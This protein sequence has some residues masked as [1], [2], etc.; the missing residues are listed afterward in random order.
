MLRALER[1]GVSRQH[2]GYLVEG[3]IEASLRGTDTHGARLFA[4]YLAELDGGRCRARPELRWS[5][6][7]PAVRVLD[8]GHALGPVAG[9]IA[10]REAVHLAEQHG[11]GAVTVRNSNYFGCCAQYTL[12]MARHDV[13]GISS[14]NS[15]ALV[16]PVG[17]G[18]PLFGT[19]PLSFAVR[20]A[21]G[22][23]FCVDMA[24]SQVSFTKIKEHREQGIPLEPGWAV[25][26]DGRDASCGEVTEVAALLP[27]GG[28]KGQCLVMMIEI[29][30][31]LLAG[32]PFDHQLSHL[33]DQPF[34][35]PRQTSH[36]FLALEI[37]AFQPLRSFRA[38]LSELMELVRAQRGAGGARGVAP[39]DLERGTF[40]QRQ[41]Q[42]IPLTEQDLTRFR[43]IDQEDEPGGT[44][45]GSAPYL[46]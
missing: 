11:V 39:G 22:D 32:M 7:R 31:C 44:C 20:G 42:G 45:R 33:Y 9:R 41:R 16:A 8:A 10:A 43:Q 36:F 21:G 6:D 24:T 2:A 29:L 37:E 30:C 12:E 3:L 27:L 46:G 15:D 23:V 28:H 34:D 25:G 13:I 5:G 35:Q 40:D 4:T 26:P 19:N 1:R 38:R 14:T 17:G 18:R